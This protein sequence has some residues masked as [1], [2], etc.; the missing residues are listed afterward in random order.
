MLNCMPKKWALFKT[1]PILIF[2][3]KI[4]RREKD[5]AKGMD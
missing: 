4:N 5:A 1:N 3:E 2:L